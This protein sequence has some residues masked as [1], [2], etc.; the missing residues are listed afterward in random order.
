MSGPN[1]AAVKIRGATL[2]AGLQEAR[3]LLRSDSS[4]AQSPSSFPGTDPLPPLTP[5]ADPPRAHLRETIASKVACLYATLLQDTGSSLRPGA[6]ETFASVFL[7]QTSGYFQTLPRI[8]A[9]HNT[10]GPREPVATKPGDHPGPL[11]DSTVS[12]FT[13]LTMH[14]GAPGSPASTPLSDAGDTAD[15]QSASSSGMRC[16]PYG[17]A[18]AAA[19]RLR[20][21]QF[22]CGGS[23]TSLSDRASGAAPAPE[24]AWQAHCGGRVRFLDA[25]AAARPSSLPCDTA[26]GGTAQMWSVDFATQCEHHILPFYGTLHAVLLPGDGGGGG[27]EVTAACLC[28][29][30]D[31]FSLRLQVQERL[32]HEVRVH[33]RRKVTRISFR[34]RLSAF[35]ACMLPLWP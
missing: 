9:Q 15:T 21:L 24:S 23:D 3:L 16:C 27:R 4:G 7:R 32:T 33:P 5:N 28:D 8:L 19:P 29:I 1:N 18:A 35:A 30:V 17:A 12:L 31:M 6:A 34:P 26:A 2:A 10:S 14:D 20:D 22:G 13:D 25:A 11:S